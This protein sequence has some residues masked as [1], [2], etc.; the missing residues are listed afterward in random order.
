MYYGMLSADSK[1]RA[2][3]ATLQMGANGARESVTNLL[4]LDLVPG[5]ISLARSTSLTDHC[6]QWSRSLTATFTGCSSCCILS[7][8]QWRQSPW[9]Q[10]L[11]RGKSQGPVVSEKPQKS[12]WEK[13]TQR[14][15]CN[16]LCQQWETNWRDAPL[17][18]EVMEDTM[19]KKQ[20]WKSSKCQLPMGYAFAL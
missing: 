5:F 11:S 9:R 12:S 4:G 15:S 20:Q 8:W 17:L 18:L 16:V 7:R 1:W 19:D 6:N 3:A 14:I 10:P 2:R 13:I